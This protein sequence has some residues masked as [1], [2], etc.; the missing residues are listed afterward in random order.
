MTLGVTLLTVAL[1]GTTG[2]EVVPDQLIVRFK[3]PSSDGRSSVSGSVSVSISRQL[4]PGRRVM[5][6][7]SLGGR[8]WLYHLAE[9]SAD[10]DLLEALRKRPDVEY[11]EPNYIRRRCLTP[12]DTWY[13]FQWNLKAINLERAWTRTSGS[14][15]VVVAVVDTGILPEHPD[16]KGRVLPGFDF[17]T[18]ANHSGD[19]DGW[20]PDPTDNGTEDTS[21]SAFHGTHLAGIIGASTNNQQGIAGVSWGC[22]LLPVRVL[23]ID[24]G[25]GTDADISA[26]IRWAAGLPVDGAPTNPNPAKVINLS[27]ANEGYGI[28]LAE[29]VSAAQKQGVIVVAAAGNGGIDGKDTYP[30]A[31]DGVITVGA[32][33]LDGS[34]AHYSNFG[35]VVKIMAPGGDLE[36]RLLHLPPKCGKNEPCPAGIVST[37]YRTS[38]SEWASGFYAGTSQAAPHV[39]GVAALMLS[40]NPAL[41]GPEVLR[42]LSSS[43]NPSG[44][45]PEGCGSGLLDAAMALDM[46][47]GVPPSTD[48]APTFNGELGSVWGGGCSTSRPSTGPTASA[49][50][51]AL[52]PLVLLLLGGALRRRR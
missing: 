5:A 10:P 1:L 39:A 31:L 15:Q 48:R 26:G 9:G 34:R 51:S 47:A 20:D 50:S 33:Q 41:D 7:R 28:T 52:A 42:I 4:L 45:C 49:V 11:A 14:S 13:A 17:I 16:L 35:E 22:R 24:K 3:P 40:I 27:F 44:Q 36:Q 37:L 6:S 19:G 12:N 29:A 21:S 8:T 32:T 25:K 2:I 46:T 43:A 23:G 18:D 38:K 30:G